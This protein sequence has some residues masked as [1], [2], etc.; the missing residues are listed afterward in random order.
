MASFQRLMNKHKANTVL[1]E[2]KVAYMNAH[3][4]GNI[5]PLNTWLGISF[6]PSYGLTMKVLRDYKGNDYVLVEGIPQSICE[7][8]LPMQ[9]EG[10]LAFYTA[11]YE[12]LTMCLNKKDMMV[13]WA[14][15]GIPAECGATTHCDVGDY[16][17]ENDPSGFPGFCNSEG[18]CQACNSDY[19]IVNEN[20]TGCECNSEVAVSCDW[21]G[22]H[23]CCEKGNLCGAEMG[24]C[25]PDNGCW[26]TLTTT[27]TDNSCHY[28]LQIVDGVATMHPEKPCGSGYCYLD[29]GSGGCGTSVSNNAT[30]LW[31][32][33]NPFT[34]TIGSCSYSSA[35]LTA[36]KACPP[37]YYCNVKWKNQSCQAVENATTTVY[38]R[39]QRVEENTNPA[40]PAPW[41]EADPT[42]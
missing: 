20:R 8:M 37:Q 14:G 19:E 28:T 30:D 31:G 27:T 10:V 13:A 25:V 33:C 5:E 9:A 22:E 2:T 41:G 4:R 23:W 3:A 1:S 6:T 17:V 36:E 42:E 35:A 7:Q 11:T 16:A 15:A 39:C 40:C 21:R 34:E 38:G 12:P 29:S 26:Y 32:K 18:R 24:E